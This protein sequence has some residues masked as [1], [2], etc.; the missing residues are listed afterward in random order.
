MTQR[1]YEIQLAKLNLEL[2][3]LKKEQTDKKRRWIV[4]KVSTSLE[5]RL[6]DERRIQAKD[7]EIRSLR[8]VYSETVATHQRVPSFAYSDRILAELTLL[9]EEHGMA[10]LVK[11]ARQTADAFF[12]AE[13]F[14]NTSKE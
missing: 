10:E 2:A 4:E 6:E 8:S 1:F 9:C 7:L 13:K 14:G 12:K 3:H 11:R 5:E